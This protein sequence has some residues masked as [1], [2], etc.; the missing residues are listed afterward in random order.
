MDSAASD[1]R[2]GSR[3]GSWA[4][5]AGR[6]ASIDMLRG[7][8]I[9]L[10]ALDHVR[11]FFHA[12]AFVFDPLDLGK[13]SVALY[14]TR[15]ITHFCAPTFIF[16][17]GASAW[18]YGARAGSRA[19][20]SRFL[21]T[22]GLWL[23]ALECSV[24]SFAWEFSLDH[25]RLQ[26][27]WAIGVSMVALSA[28]VWLPRPAI[29][30]VAMLLM[31]GHNLSDAV[32]PERAGKLGT[33]WIFLHAGGDIP[34]NGG[35]ELRV[36]YPLL[37]WIGVMAFGYVLGAVF[38]FNAARRARF[39]VPLGTTMICG[40]LLL[41]TVHG[42]GD[43]RD[44]YFHESAWATLGD[45]LDTRKYPPSLLYLLMTLGPAFA[46]LP[47]LERLKGAAARVLL[48]YG[49]VP[50]FFYA[51]H[52]YLAHGAMLLAGVAGGYPAGMFVGPTSDRAIAA[53]G[54]GLSLAGV[55]LVWAAVLA[56]LYPICRWFGEIKRRRRD[57]W[58]SYL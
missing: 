6:L 44:W 23:V 39:L 50:L 47:P 52:L 18:L 54:W 13:T 27:I 43:P 49:R 32:T 17:A 7:L 25:I 40:F 42:Y 5:S 26:V 21:L 19:A 33:L 4:E 31:A 20:L 28:L 56:A 58:L 38:R 36:I 55:Y 30:A 29:L 2:S 46:L 12:D 11:D 34:L 53:S 37:P 3:D 1:M 9:M 41:R 48:C 16:L 24:V 22:R 57:W 8:V 51:A 14:F 10:M 45:F 15:W 35:I